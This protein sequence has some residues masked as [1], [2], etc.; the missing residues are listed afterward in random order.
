MSISL[1]DIYFFQ[2]IDNN[3]INKI[4]DNSRREKIKKWSI[5]IEQWEKPDNTAYIIQEWSVNVLINWNFITEL[6]EWNV[7]WEI[8]LITNENR[9]ATIKAKTDV[10][11]LKINKELL[12]SVMKELPNWEEIKKEVFKRIQNNLKSK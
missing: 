12:F 1:K 10:I 8:A 3:F 2:W 9:T 6:K 5:I 7:F 4:I 11:L